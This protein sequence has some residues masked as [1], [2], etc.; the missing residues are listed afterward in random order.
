MDER[1]KTTL[2]NGLAAALLSA[3][4]ASAVAFTVLPVLMLVR[5]RIGAAVMLLLFGWSVTLALSVLGAVLVRRLGAAGQCAGGPC[6]AR[7]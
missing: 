3:C 6:T 2:A 4:G 5:G 1:R 7:H